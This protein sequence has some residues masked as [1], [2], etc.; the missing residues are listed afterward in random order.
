V[1]V[2]SAFFTI[3]SSFMSAIT[4]EKGLHERAICDCGHYTIHGATKSYCAALLSSLCVRYDRA[5]ARHTRSGVRLKS[6]PPQPLHSVLCPLLY[7]FADI[8]FAHANSDGRVYVSRVPCKL[9]AGMCMREVRRRYIE[10][11]LSAAGRHIYMRYA[12]VHAEFVAQNSISIP[13]A[14]IFI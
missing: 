11:R 12:Y 10:H 7:V 4:T 13:A 3:A 1:A 8:C 2:A 5:H 9:G 6:C 14:L